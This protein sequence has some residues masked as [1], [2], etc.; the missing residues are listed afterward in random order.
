MLPGSSF[1]I[2]LECDMPLS[3]AGG[4]LGDIVSMLVQNPGATDRFGCRIPEF[5]SNLDLRFRFQVICVVWK[6]EHQ[7]LEK[8]KNGEQ[9]VVSECLLKNFQREV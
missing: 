2:P 7:Y 9:P 8:G 4:I 5:Q 1:V 3:K 6:I